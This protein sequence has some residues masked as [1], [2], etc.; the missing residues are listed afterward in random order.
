MNP[1]KYKKIIVTVCRLLIGLVFIFSGFVKAVDPWGSAYKFHDYFVAWNITFLDFSSLPASFFLSAL[2]FVLGVCLLAGVYR[3]IVSGIILLFMSFMTVLTLYLAIFNPVT[4]CG[5]FG[6]ALII[7]NWQTFYKNLILI[8]AAVIIFVW[9]K[10]VVS[11]FSVKSRSLVVLFTGLFILSVSFYSYIY[12]PVLDFR[13]YKIGN[14]IHELMQ[15]P[16][17]AE[18]DVYETVFIYEK[19]GVKQE[20]SL[21]NYP[22]EDSGWTFVETINTLVKKGYEPKIHDFALI[23]ANGDDLTEEI[24]S[25]P[26][27]TFLLII[28]KLEQADDANVDQIN[29]LYDYAHQHGYP[30]FCLTASTPQQIREWWESTG[31]EYPFCTVDDVTLKT[32][33]RSNPGVLLLQDASIVNKWPHSRLP[34]GEALQQPLEESVLGVPPAN[35]DTRNVVALAVGLIAVLA[36]VWVFDKKRQKKN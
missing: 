22:Q 1:N 2:E 4:D 10:Q 9:R 35:H 3:R 14:N 19:D 12:L 6:D 18:R 34:K 25:N 36:L 24:L 27:Y 13:P 28:H 15:I 7:T 29:E 16:E 5:C 21:S 33:I 30:F 17:G 31:A 26:G 32:V 8:T 11:L 20:F 23:S